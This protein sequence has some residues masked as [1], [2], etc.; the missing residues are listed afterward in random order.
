MPKH[1]NRREL[2][3]ISDILSATMDGG[4]SGVIIS[5]IARKAN[6]SHDVAIEKCQKL[7]DKGL[8]KSIRN[9]R[10]RIII[11]TERGI[12]F[13]QQIR[14]FREKAQELKMRF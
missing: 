10:N 3:V 2:G 12:Q 11:I 7:I 13:F 6:I 9:G 4:K 1:K 8:V 5:T 14:E